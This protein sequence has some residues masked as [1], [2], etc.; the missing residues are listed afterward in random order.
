MCSSDLEEVRYPEPDQ[1]AARAALTRHV[2]TAAGVVGEPVSSSG[3]RLLRDGGFSGGLDP[4]GSSAR[5]GISGVWW[6]AGRR[7]PLRVAAWASS[8]DLIGGY[9]RFRNTIMM[10]VLFV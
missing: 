7:R 6:L 4:V 1:L 9:H 3:V 2:R 10:R 5:G 8:C